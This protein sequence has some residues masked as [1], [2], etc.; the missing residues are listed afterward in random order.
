MKPLQLRAGIVGFVASGAFACGGQVGGD[1]TL[2]HDAGSA[3]TAFV[4]E[5]SELDAGPTCGT[6]PGQ[7]NPT[8]DEWLQRIV[9]PNWP[10]HAV[11]SLGQCQLE[12]IDAVF[13]SCTTGASG[14]A[15]CA[16]WASQF[17]PPGGSVQEVCLGFEGNDVNGNCQ[18]PDFCGTH[19]GCGLD[20]LCVERAGIFA[21]ESLCR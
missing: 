11:C 4:P 13:P 8:C 14:D 17:V 19:P 15:Y 3:C 10:G 6:P 5:S 21:C 1:P 7:D 12:L 20:Q 2:L 18:Q 16:G 9:P